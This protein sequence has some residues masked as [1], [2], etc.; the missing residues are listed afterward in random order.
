MKTFYEI[1]IN[2]FIANVTNTFIWFALTFWVYLETQSVIS[3][4]IVGGVYL[5]ATTLSGIWFGSIVDH[6]KKKASM[7]G[8]SI[9]TLLFFIYLQEMMHS[10]Q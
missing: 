2:T 4:G 5:I 10:N 7:M 8:S 9:A 1:L 6:Y 3:T